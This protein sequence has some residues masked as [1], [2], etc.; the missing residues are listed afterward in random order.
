METF[1]VI[2]K[3]ELNLVLIILKSIRKI[4]K[5]WQVQIV[6]Q[7]DFEFISFTLL[8]DTVSVLPNEKFLHFI[9]GGKKKDISNDTLRTNAH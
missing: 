3:K 6:F 8:T 4:H 1:S 5:C 2:A 7:R 9:F